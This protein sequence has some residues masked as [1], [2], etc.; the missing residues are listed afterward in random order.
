MEQLTLIQSG[1]IPAPILSSPEENQPS[2]PRS[3]L[4]PTP[5]HI[6]PYASYKSPPRD[7]AHRK[8]MEARKLRADQEEESKG[9]E[10]RRDQ[11]GWAK[12]G[13]RGGR[14]RTTRPVRVTAC[15]GTCVHT[16]IVRACTYV[17]MH[18]C[19]MCVLG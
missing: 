4:L 15:V 14:K 3:A 1:K 6:L 5:A 19:I 10:G 7:R 12:G 17:C 18:T 9:G 8:R 11:G 2:R 13:G 16:Y